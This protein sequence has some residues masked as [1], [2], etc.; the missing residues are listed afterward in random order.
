MIKRRYGW[1]PDLPDARDFSYKVTAPRIAKMPDKVDL[2]PDCSPVED[3][4]SL[5][6]CTANACAGNIEYLERKGVDPVPEDPKPVVLSWWKRIL[7]FFGLYKVSNPYG[8]GQYKD[9]SRLFIYYNARTIE[10]TASE[11]SGAFLRDCMK[12]L[13][14]D[15]HCLERLCPYDISKFT[16]R[17][18]LQA[19]ADGH[20]HVIQSYS[21]L[22]SLNEMQT[23]LADGFPFVL[24]I[25]LYESFESDEVRKTGVVNMPGSY[26]R[27]IGG[28][29][30]MAVG[31]DN[32][33]QRFLIRNSWGDSWGQQGYF[34]IPYTYVTTLGDDFWTIR[35]G[36][37][38]TT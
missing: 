21:R 20:L 24:G 26:E 35:K 18:S 36:N 38:H 5:G 4:G 15:G 32:S 6:S 16:Q 25:T 27:V 13:A 9:A 8:G 17:P 37:G 33:T 29:A 31:Y 22:S 10:G 30:V 19:Y 23:C 7:S 2:R 34:T 12:T 11:D 3:Q 1:K 14:R 28:H